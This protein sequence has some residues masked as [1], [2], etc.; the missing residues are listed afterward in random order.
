MKAYVS[1][2]ALHGA[3]GLLGGML[4]KLWSLHHDY[5]VNE[6]QL[7]IFARPVCWMNCPVDIWFPNTR[8]K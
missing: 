4:L 2:G 1:S 8:L 5:A 7:A 3:V 6:D